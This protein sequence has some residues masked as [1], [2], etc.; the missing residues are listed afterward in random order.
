MTGR[1]QVYS[2][3]AGVACLPGIH[4]CPETKSTCQACQVH[5]QQVRSTHPSQVHCSQVH[6]GQV[7]LGQ[8]LPARFTAAMSTRS[9]PARSTRSTFRRSGPQPQGCTYKGW[10]PGSLLIAPG[11][12]SGHL[13]LGLLA[14]GQGGVLGLEMGA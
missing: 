10:R 12:Q 11:V 7:H 1:A 4:L 6:S 13:D 9:T 5:F 3:Q 14:E 8:D 2:R